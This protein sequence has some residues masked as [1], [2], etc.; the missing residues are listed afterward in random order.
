MTKMVVKMH[1]FHRKRI[2]VQWKAALHAEFALRSRNTNE[3]KIECYDS[4]LKKIV[5][6]GE[7]RKPQQP[8]VRNKSIDAFVALIEEAFQPEDCNYE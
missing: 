1:K 8:W 3:A 4:P 5:T 7:R 6:R 2:E